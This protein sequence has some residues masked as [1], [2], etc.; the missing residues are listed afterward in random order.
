MRRMAVPW[1]T[2]WH[3]ASRTCC[4]TGSREMVWLRL[5]RRRCALAHGGLPL[6]GWRSPKPV[7]ER[8]RQGQMTQSEWP[9]AVRI[10][11]DQLFLLSGQRYQKFA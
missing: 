5:G 4:W 7:D 3:M 9:H 8:F 11:P 2:C 10:L 6:S 1:R